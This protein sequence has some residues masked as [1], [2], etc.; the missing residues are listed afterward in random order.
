MEGVE[1]LLAEARVFLDAH[2][3]RTPADAA[4]VWGQGSDGVSMFEEGSLEEQLAVVA[5][6][7]AWAAVRF[8]AGFGWIDGPVELG[9]RA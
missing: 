7:Q 6:E 4:F 9:G 3:T 2:A 8:D 1:A 5:R